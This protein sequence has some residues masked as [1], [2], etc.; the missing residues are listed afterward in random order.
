MLRIFLIFTIMSS[1]I[2]AE[3]ITVKDILFLVDLGVE[4][5]EIIRHIK[6][7][8]NKTVLSQ[9]DINLLKEKG[10]SSRIMNALTIADDLSAASIVQKIKNGN[11][12]D[13]IILQIDNAKKMATYGVDE[14][15]LLHR[16]KVPQKIIDALKRKTSKRKNRVSIADVRKW[17]AG[18]ETSSQI[19]AKLKKT[20]VDTST[21]NSSVLL[22]L[23]EEGLPLD[24]L[25]FLA[26][27]HLNPDKKAV[28]EIKNKRP[29]KSALLEVKK[30]NKQPQKVKLAPTKLTSPKSNEVYVKLYPNASHISLPN[31]QEQ[32]ISK[33]KRDFYC[34]LYSTSIPLEKIETFYRKEYKKPQIARINFNEVVH[35]LKLKFYVPGSNEL[36]E[37]RCYSIDMNNLK[38][39]RNIDT[40]RKNITKN[41]YAVEKITKQIEAQKYLYKTKNISLE[42]RNKQLSV[43]QS[44]LNIM[45]NTTSY[46]DHIVIKHVLEKKQNMLLIVQPT[47]VSITTAPK[48]GLVGQISK[49]DMQP[50]KTKTLAK[51]YPL[52]VFPQATLIS[53]EKMEEGLKRTSKSRS[54]YRS[55]FLCN[56]STDTVEAYYR[57]YFKR[58][59]VWSIEYLGSFLIIKAK[60]E[61]DEIR[62]QVEIAFYALNIG[63]SSNRWQSRQ[64]RIKERLKELERSVKNIDNEINALRNLLARN[65]ISADNAQLRIRSLQRKKQLKMNA[66][67]YWDFIVMDKVMTSQN[68][69][70][71]VKEIK[72]H[73]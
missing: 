52:V 32:V 33:V 66:S 5:T 15:L 42:E 39:I 71:L 65:K 67:S 62:S 58:A 25:R 20:K 48:K 64:K 40:I 23:K 4:E 45:L 22:K 44:K 3:S 2:W 50:V 37:I 43:L 6:Q 55:L 69:I 38:R 57:K 10:I 59:S 36:M 31:F 14:W 13:K 27:M 56:A 70:L 8:E 1:C 63:P 30:T 49:I 51:D 9:E 24:L 16:N 73:F 28:A 46:W 35:I 12:I 18:G 34:S 19:I 21:I 17:F 68:S 41:D 47:N 60:F 54:V 26:E 11:S 29:E 61:V 53:H 7:A 72:R